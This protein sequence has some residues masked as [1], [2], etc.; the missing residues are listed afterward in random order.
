MEYL[1]V[2]HAAGAEHGA[3]NDGADLT[4]NSAF[5]RPGAENRQLQSSIVLICRSDRRSVDAGIS[6]EES[7]FS[8]VINVPEGFE[9]PIDERHPRRKISGWR[10]H[11]LPWEQC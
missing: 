7:G 5:C 8:E 9:G 11:A 6:L 1:L 2:G 10:F 4:I 3:W